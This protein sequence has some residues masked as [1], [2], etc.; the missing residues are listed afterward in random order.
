MEKSKIKS[1]AL[2]LVFGEVLF[3]EFHGDSTNKQE[4]S[5][6]KKVL[7]GAPFNVAWNLAMLNFDVQFISAVGNDKNGDVILQTMQANKMSTDFIEQSSLPTGNVKVMLKNGEPSYEIVDNVAYDDI[8]ISQ[9]KFSA[10]KTNIQKNYNFS[11][12]YHGSLALRHKKNYDLLQQLTREMSLPVFL[13]VNLRSPWYEKKM[14]QEFIQQAR[15]LKLNL[16]EFAILFFP[17]RFP[18][19]NEDKEKIFHLMQQHNLDNIILTAD[20]QGAA[21][22][23]K[24][25]MWFS[26]IVPVKNFQDAVGAGDAFSSIFLTGIMLQKSP[27]EILL[28]ALEFASHVCSINGAIS[29]DKN[30]YND[31]VQSW[32]KNE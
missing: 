24:N 9:K 32:G 15:W 20:K 18:V 7:G 6:P 17:L 1:K 25:E 21:I 2:P 8:G 4:P 23:T 19:V 14:V 31:I 28:K 12:L 22:F 30:F 27:N 16:Q 26:E 10:L 29:H 13:D 5:E 11:L 3:D